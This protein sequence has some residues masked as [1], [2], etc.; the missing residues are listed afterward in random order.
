M[1]EMTW[2]QKLPCAQL[3][4]RGGSIGEICMC[5]CAEESVLAMQF[6]RKGENELSQLFVYIQ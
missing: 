6:L 5:V 4:L 1:M 2:N 3:P